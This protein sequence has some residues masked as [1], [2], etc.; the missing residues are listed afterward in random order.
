[1]GMIKIPTASEEFFN[2]NYK[3]IFTSG[4]LAEGKWNKKVSEWT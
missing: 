4:N 1:M 3:E 2:E